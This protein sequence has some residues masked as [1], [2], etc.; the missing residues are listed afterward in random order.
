MRSGFLCLLVFAWGL[1]ASG[2]D[3][4]PDREPDPDGGAGPQV[5]VEGRAFGLES[6]SALAGLGVQTSQVGGA[7][8]AMDTT[9]GEGRFS[10]TVSPG[11][12]LVRLESEDHGPLLLTLDVPDD[13]DSTDFEAFVPPVTAKGGFQVAKGGAIEDSEGGLLKV[14]PD[15]VEGTGSVQV[16]LMSVNPSKAGGAKGVPGG[17]VASAGGAPAPVRLSGVLGVSLTH[18]DGSPAQ[19]KPGQEATL[20][21]PAGGGA[22]PSTHTLFSLNESTGEWVAEG[23]ATKTSGASTGKP[24]YRAKVPHLS[25]WA[26]GEMATPGCLGGCVVDDGGSP[27]AG[28]TVRLAASDGSYARRVLTAADGCYE[29]EAPADLSLTAV[30]TAG[31]RAS[32]PASGTPSATSCG[33]VP[34]LQLAVPSDEGC[35]GGFA[36]CDEACVDT[37]DD[38][39]HCGGCDVSCADETD[40]PVGA[41]CVAGACACS[42]SEAACTVDGV[43][44]CVVT[45]DDP[46]HCGE[47]G[48]SCEE[49]TAC[50]DGA[51]VATACGD[52]ALQAGEHCFA[53]HLA[54]LPVGIEPSR[55]A[56]ADFDGDGRRDLAVVS[57]AEDA[58]AVL[59]ATPRG[60]FEVGEPIPTGASPLDMV[61]TDYDGDGAPDLVV[62]AVDGDGGTGA[63]H[64]HRNDGSGG[65]TEDPPIA[66]SRPWHVA[67]GDFDGDGRVDLAVGSQNVDELRVML[68]QA[69]GGFGSP[70]STPLTSFAFAVRAADL[71]D[72]GHDEI[73]LLQQPIEGGM[74]VE[75]FTVEGGT[76]TSIGPSP[77]GGSFQPGGLV[78]A[79]VTGDGALDALVGRA[80]E[81]GSPEL[82]PGDGAG[83]FGDAIVVD[84]ELV[85][86]G[87]AWPAAGRVRADAT[88]ADV[89]VVDPAGEQVHLYGYDDTGGAFGFLGTHPVGANPVQA[90]LEDFDGDGL[91]DLAVAN[92]AADTI[93]L[94][95]PIDDGAEAPPLTAHTAPAGSNPGTALVGDLNNDGIDDL[96]VLPSSGDIVPVLGRATGRPEPTDPLP[97]ST[98]LRGG[99]LGDLDADGVL[100]VAAIT[101]TDGTVELVRW[102]GNG[103]GTFG[104]PEVVPI[105]PTIDAMAAGDLNGDGRADVVL[106]NGELQQLEVR[107]S[108]AMGVPG[109]A[110]PIDHGDLSF[111][112]PAIADVTGDGLPDL[113]VGTG[114]GVD[115]LLGDGAGGFGAAEPVPLSQMPLQ[116]DVA[117]VDGDG[118]LDIVTA[119]E[120]TVEAALGDGAG[121]FA[122]A[123][124]S[125]TAGVFAVAAG[126]LDGDGAADLVGVGTDGLAT[127]VADGDGAFTDTGFRSEAGRLPER[128][129]IGDFD[130]DGVPDLAC[131]NRG[132]DDLTVVYASP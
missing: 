101:D 76:L 98:A 41:A 86:D 97:V 30:A 77:E 122:S 56:A 103:D 78:L 43:D 116:V 93:T 71:D 117:D 27:A 102:L 81:A 100:D 118:R 44:E 29:V 7:A 65:F 79:D 96:V 129:A 66:I 12:S 9:D 47:C 73:A 83:G 49:G 74:V 94:R 64:L 34:E 130:G 92:R 32:D 106:V 38:P 57:E 62:A 36:R 132:S 1:V 55:M 124:V 35:P 11:K 31:D 112:P 91:S 107:L 119:S 6:A 14:P 15:A 80:S 70:L 69:D 68:Q 58:I 26:I 40:G 20:H 113:V 2:C 128:P 39:A 10:A 60:T 67:A 51:C 37:S 16:R 111:A 17:G 28:A 22:Q 105:P 4:E 99:G 115:V 63:L 13:V 126:D 87:G 125:D 50:E 23:T 84:P 53:P 120:G 33:T 104:E 95:R 114:M 54:D 90:L 127:F 8:G 72:D 82:F 108:D 3:D 19:I 46:Q 5:T 131:V 25:F 61:A 24:G 85:V 52:G 21:I 110:T 123:G 48:M 109:A 89:A 121:G 45:D 18:D 75:A 59:R 42:V 88:G